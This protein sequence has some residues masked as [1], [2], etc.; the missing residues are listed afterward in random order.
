MTGTHV[1]RKHPRAES[2]RIRER[3]T[4]HIET[5]V[6][7]LAGLI[8]HGRGE[9]FD[10]ILGEKTTPSA[11][12]AIAAAAASLLLA[13]HPVLSVN[14]N[15]AALCAEELVK[16]AKASNAKLEVNLFHRLPGREAAIEK[17]LRDAGAEEVL[18]VGDAASARIDEVNSDRRMVDPRGILVAD[19]VFVP[20][21]DG[22]RTEALRRMGKT[23]IA[24]D[25]NPLSR[26][27]QL[28]SITIV[29]NIVRAMPLLVSEVERLRVR[30]KEELRTVISEFSNEDALSDA[31][32]RMEERLHALAEKGVYI[33][34]NG[35][36]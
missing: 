13:E 23:V 16:L 5:G 4:R 30:R 3:L 21:E 29:D 33:E 7:A 28:A 35:G 8:A 11:R 14:G 19:V 1:S 36:R 9:A 18:G 34:L 12:R 6:V 32:R 15:V 10:Y 24:V 26:T 22:D 17:L 27:A 25:L 20:L 31:M 2:I